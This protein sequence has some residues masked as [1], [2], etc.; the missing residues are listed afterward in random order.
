MGF[1]VFYTVLGENEKA[2][3]WME[4]AI[5]QRHPAALFHLRYMTAC[6]TGPRWPKL[7]GMLNLPEDAWTDGRA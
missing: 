4:K 6:R 1:A 3:E 2:L 7:M 5:E